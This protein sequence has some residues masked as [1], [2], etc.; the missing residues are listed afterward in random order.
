[1]R[2][3]SIAL[4]VALAAG[5]AGFAASAADNAPPARVVT[6]PTQR[7]GS[8]EP[9][10]QSADAARHEA[11]AAWAENRRACREET[12]RNARR[13]CLDAARADHDRLLAEAAGR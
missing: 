2:T 8:D 11:A 7:I 10:P 12:D 5:A 1:M 6:L 9:G 4:I 3:P 13:E